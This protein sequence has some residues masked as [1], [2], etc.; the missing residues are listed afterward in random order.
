[1]GF[2]PAH[3]S[4]VPL[5]LNLQTGHTSPQYHVVFD[6]QFSTVLSH[7]S[8]KDPP[9]WWIEIYIEENSSMIHLD[10]G[11]PLRIL[12]KDWF[13]PDELEERSRN[14]IG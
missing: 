12:V 9:T 14:N 11:L 5:I 13:S 6:D 8:D 7:H 3:S 4:D 10:D 1:M 2:S